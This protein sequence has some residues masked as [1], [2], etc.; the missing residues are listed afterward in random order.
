MYALRVSINGEVPVVAGSEDLGVL[1]AIVNCVGKL[2]N[3]GRKLEE[4]E[5]ADLFLHVGGLTSRH[6]K[7]TDEHV[8]WIINRTL[9]VD[10]V[11]TIEIIETGSADSPTDAHAAKK[12]QDDE[13]EYFE[14]CKREYLELREK[15][16]I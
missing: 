14:H 10:D 12:R 16:E 3:S 11:V 7:S 8:R 2:G 4:Q 15:Y 9:C 13:R 1:N 5:D 6:D